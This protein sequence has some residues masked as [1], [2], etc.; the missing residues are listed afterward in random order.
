MTLSDGEFR[1]ELPDLRARPSQ[2]LPNVPH[3]M[4]LY[5]ETSMDLL[6]PRPIDATHHLPFRFETNQ[7]FDTPR[8]DEKIRDLNLDTLRPSGKTHDSNLDAPHP[9]K[10]THDP[11][12]DT[13]HPN[14][15][16]HD[17]YSYD[18]DFDTVRSVKNNRH[19]HSLIKT[20][21]N[22]GWSEPNEHVHHVH[23][24]NSVD[25]DLEISHL[26]D[27]SPQQHHYESDMH[28]H[29]SNLNEDAHHFLFKTDIDTP[30][31]IE[32]PNHASKTLHKPRNRDDSYLKE[33]EMDSN[34]DSPHSSEDL[35]FQPDV[36]M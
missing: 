22:F 9:D 8:L 30:R 25:P 34:L 1:T 19:V 33:Q 24:Q 4:E 14:E 36:Y 20:D 7:D 21:R 18:T 11:N 13:L 28:F 16:T 6:T 32:D 17:L 35:K 15:I 5:N 26:V 29:T 27:H 3:H 10:I 31:D 2:T 12:L 23:F